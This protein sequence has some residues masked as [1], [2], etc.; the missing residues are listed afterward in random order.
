MNDVEASINLFL[1][2]DNYKEMFKGD[3]L[4]VVYYILPA[5]K[6]NQY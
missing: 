6:L 1:Q 3:I 5:I 4:S 2:A